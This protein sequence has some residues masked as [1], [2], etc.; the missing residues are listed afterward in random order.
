MAN[1]V[2]HPVSYNSTKPFRVLAAQETNEIIYIDDI[3]DI[4]SGWVQDKTTVYPE[5]R[6]AACRDP[7][8]ALWKHKIVRA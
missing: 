4:A 7:G 2:K 1:P 6:C 3:W 8:R 5:I